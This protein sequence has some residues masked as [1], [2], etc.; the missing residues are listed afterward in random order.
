[1][2]NTTIQYHKVYETHEE[3]DALFSTNLSYFVH[4]YLDWCYV[5]NLVIFFEKLLW[6]NCE[7]I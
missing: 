1:M 7:N 3:N 2:I 4:T 6:D 5:Q